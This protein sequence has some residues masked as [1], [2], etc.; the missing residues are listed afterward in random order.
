MTTIAYT[1]GVM[2]SDSCWADEGLRTSSLIKIRRLSSGALYGGAGDSDD[3]TLVGVLDKIRTPDRLP[4][5]E[6]LARLDGDFE[7][8]LVFPQ[9][10]I[11][12]LTKSGRDAQIWECNRGLMAIGSGGEIAIGAMASGKSARE[13]VAVACDWDTNSRLPVHVLELRCKRF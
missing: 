9:G 3:R 12:K 8:L 10:K 13:A 2:A 1:K 11:L 5:R 6:D 7:A 4:S